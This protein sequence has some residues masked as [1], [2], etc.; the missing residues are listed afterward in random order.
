LILPL[1]GVLLES[2]LWVLLSCYSHVTEMLFLG[3]RIQAMKT[4]TMTVN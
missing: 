2:K 3:L 4:G 1:R